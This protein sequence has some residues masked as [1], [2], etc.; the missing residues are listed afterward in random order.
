[1]SGL[2][3]AALIR[4]RKRSAH[5]PIIFL[6][7]FADE[8]HVAEGYAQGAVDYITTPVVPA[9]LCAKVRVFCDL[10]RMSQKVLRQAE[11]RIVLAEERSKRE[12]AE[13][14]NRRLAFLTRAGEVL[15]Q[16]L[17]QEVTARDVVHLPL[18]LLAD[19]ARLA[20]L[21]PDRVITRSYQARRGTEDGRIEDLPPE[22]SVDPAL[23]EAI[24]R[25]LAG[26]STSSDGA[27]VIAL[28]IRGGERLF[29]VLGLSRTAS[30]REFTHADVTVA[31]M[32]ASRAASALEN[33]QLYHEVQ[34][35]DR[36]KN[37]FL[38][39]LAPRTAQPT[40]ADPQ[41]E[42]GPSPEG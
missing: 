19:E 23:I 7:A 40:G 4:R 24:G 6:T 14:A 15:G 2:E 30:G 36:Q 31:R 1:M 20:I 16:S 29:A 21:G 32:F 26:V 41:R 12:A 18:P 27:P 37:E 35:A 11:E 3:T 25:S 42:R 9:V 13:E 22:A 10:Y 38:S 8:V 5:T 33:A 17:D 39:M 34:E 28:P